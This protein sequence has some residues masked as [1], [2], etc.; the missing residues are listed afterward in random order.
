MGRSKGNWL[1]GASLLTVNFAWRP[2]SDFG[3]FNVSRSCRAL[4]IRVL[5]H[6]SGKC[7][8][9]PVIRNWAP[10]AWAHSRNRLSE[11]SAEIVNLWLGS[12][13]VAGARSAAIVA[14]M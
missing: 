7:R 11:S 5:F 14:V 13:S 10:E 12:V 3:S 2:Y 4:T 8:L 1:Q 9:L 6:I